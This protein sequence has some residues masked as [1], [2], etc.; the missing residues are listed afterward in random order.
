M[1][2]RSILVEE[3]TLREYLKT[4]WRGF[5]TKDYELLTAMLLAEFHSK[6]FG[7]GFHIAFPVK[8]QTDREVSNEYTADNIEQVLKRFI[9]EDTP[10]DLL[11][12]PKEEVDPWP[13]SAREAK[14][15]GQAF[16][17]KRIAARTGGDSTQ[18]ILNLLEKIAKHYASIQAGLVLVIGGGKTSGSVDMDRIRNSFNFDGFPFNRVMFI[19]GTA[20]G[21]L[22]GEIWPNFGHKEYS[23]ED[24]F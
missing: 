8:Q 12:V 7:G 6:Q 20:Q 13:T 11:V 19:T 18:E 5:D 23:S 10:I 17:L 2:V 14:A 3:S 9:N 4:H 1:I 24:L 21:V 16:Q 22:F 15:K